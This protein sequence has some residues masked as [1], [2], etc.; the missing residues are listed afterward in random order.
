MTRPIAPP[1][2]YWVIQK[3]GR[4]VQ[5]HETVAEHLGSVTV[6]IPESCDTESLSESE[7]RDATPETALLDD[8]EKDV[9]GL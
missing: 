2:R 7:L 3:E 8:H 1:S 4:T 9:L 6:V 5:R